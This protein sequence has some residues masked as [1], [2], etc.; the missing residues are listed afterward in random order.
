MVLVQSISG[1]VFFY[2]PLQALLYV[3]TL[4]PFSEAVLILF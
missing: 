2:L 1:Y 3:L 4:A